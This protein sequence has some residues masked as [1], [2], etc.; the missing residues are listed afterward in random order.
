[1]LNFS[2]KPLFLSKIFISSWQNLIFNKTYIYIWLNLYVLAQ[3]KKFFLVK[4]ISLTKPPSF[5]TEPLH[6]GKKFIY[7]LLIFYPLGKP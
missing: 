4:P 1:M 7:L 5:M 6:V 3:K 2:L